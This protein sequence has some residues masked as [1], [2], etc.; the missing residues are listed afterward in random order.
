MEDRGCPSSVPVIIVREVT[1]IP[2]QTP[3]TKY[4]IPMSL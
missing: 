3:N 1:A 4:H 2:D